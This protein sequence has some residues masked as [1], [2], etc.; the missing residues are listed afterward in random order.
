MPEI[1]Q[2]PDFFN[3]NKIFGGIFGGNGR[4]TLPHQYK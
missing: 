4:P 1:I 2:G 3:F